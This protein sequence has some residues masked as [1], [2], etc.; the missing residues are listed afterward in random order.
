MVDICTA[1]SGSGFIQGGVTPIPPTAVTWTWVWNS[2]PGSVYHDVIS[3]DAA[4]GVAGSHQLTQ[5][6]VDPTSFHVTSSSQTF[7][8]GAVQLADIYAA[9]PGGT[10]CGTYRFYNAANVEVFDAGGGYCAYGSQ[11]KSGVPNIVYL[12]PDALVAIVGAVT[13]GWGWPLAAVFLGNALNVGALCASSRPPETHI[14]LDDMLAISSYPPTVASVT[15]LGKAYAWLKWAAWPQFCECIPGTPSTA[16]PPTVIVTAPTGAPPGPIVTCDDTDICTQIQALSLALAAIAQSQKNMM[17]MLTLVQRQKVP[18][19]FLEGARHSGLTGAGTFDV[20]G[21]LGLSVQS[22]SVPG[23][24]SAS[25]APVNSYFRLGEL[26]LGTVQGW[27][28]RTLV[29]H[30]PHLLLDVEGDITK[31]GYLFEAGVVADIVELVR[32]P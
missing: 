27:E 25:M 20:Q 5:S 12:A 19:A 28:R 4:G 22:T 13:D 24:L 7:I 11:V 14:T 29:T 3:Y 8:T 21:I 30:N 1:F 18:F 9:G 32:E 2:G 23:Y 26:S 6:L 16:T 17:N 15:S 10:Y 31:V